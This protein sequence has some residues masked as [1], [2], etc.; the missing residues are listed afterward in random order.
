MS[1]EEI[2]D[3][4]NN[5]FTDVPTKL[6]IKRSNLP[7][8]SHTGCSTR[9]FHFTSI[10]YEEIVSRINF[11]DSSKS[12]GVNQIPEFVYKS[13]VNLIALPLA[14][15]FNESLAS[16]SFPDSLK[17]PLVTPIYKIGKKQDPSNYRPISS[18]SILSKIF[19]SILKDQ[20][21]E[22]LEKDKL[23]CN[24]QFGYR[25]NHS[26]EQLLL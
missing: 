4:M 15:V 13:I 1:E 21:M 17:I 20:L 3:V 6:N 18:L 25:K 19:E 23:L 8:A 7:I 14:I 22:F 9:S 12:G 11:L 5:F 16:N 26:S 2:A 24:R 10:S